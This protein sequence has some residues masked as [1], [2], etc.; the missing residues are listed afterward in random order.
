M[1]SN[2]SN[3]LLVVRVGILAPPLMNK[4]GALVIEPPAVLPKVNVLVTDMLDAN[5]PVPV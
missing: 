2:I 3:Q 1:K 4:L 5:P